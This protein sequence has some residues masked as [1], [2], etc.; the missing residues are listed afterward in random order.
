MSDYLSRLVTRTLLEPAIRPRL[1]P[2]FGPAKAQG[3]EEFAEYTESVASTEIAEPGRVP[4]PRPSAEPISVEASLDQAPAKEAHL[5]AAPREVE[6]APA[7]AGRI[8]ATPSDEN[9]DGVDRVAAA[10]ARVPRVES[11]AEGRP[12][13][14]PAAFLN[15]PV[16]LGAAAP[17]TGEA[18]KGSVVAERNPAVESAVP[19]TVASAP[20]RAPQLAPR[21]ESAKTKNS[22]VVSDVVV[23]Q[24]VPDSKDAAPAAHREAADWVTQGATT[25][26]SPPRSAASAAQTPFAS[27][28]QRPA[29][30][31]ALPARR[32]ASTARLP[33]VEPEEASESTIQITI[34]RLEI[35]AATATASA[36]ARAPN[37]APK[38]STLEEYL[39]SRAKGSRS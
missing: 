8:E 20:Q 25:L 16:P 28:R 5:E 26:A 35:R 31:E 13:V 37:A 4:A 15:S 12:N 10:Q 38:Q 11:I 9:E 27:R 30:Q 34:G 39:R 6:V 29:S 22:E 21:Q 2:L 23:R 33:V 17:L 14:A 7:A 3:P 32:A 19:A 18:V 1:Q 36:P 24:R